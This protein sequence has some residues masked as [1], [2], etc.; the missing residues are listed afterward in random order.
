MNPFLQLNEQGGDWEVAIK[1]QSGSQSPPPPP[2]PSITPNQ[3]PEESLDLL[4]D[5]ISWKERQETGKQEE[6][7]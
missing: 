3:I 5:L 7:K 6:R 2:L 4:D 1:M